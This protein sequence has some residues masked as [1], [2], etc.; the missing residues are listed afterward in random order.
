MKA[1]TIEIFLPGGNPLELE[2]ATLTTSVIKVV[3]INQSELENSKERINQNGCYVLYGRDE[4]EESIIY[5]GEADNIF[6]RLKQH[7]KSKNFWNQ[8]YAIQHIGNRF[9]KANLHFLE[10][11]MIKEALTANRYR[12]ANGNK[13]QKNNITESKEAESINFFEDIKLILHTLGLDLFKPKNSK[14]NLNVTNIFYFKSHSVGYNASAIYE[15]DELT[16]L[17]GSIAAFKIR[18]SNNKSNGGLQ[19]KLIS[20]DVLKENDGMYVFVK[21]YTFTSPSAAGGI[22]SGSS[23]NGWT[24]WKNANNKTL[25]EMFRNK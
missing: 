7:K 25:D 17:E 18:K 16:V 3:H 1:K 11:L 8:A 9:D 23:T 20:E 15:N 10:N 14:V 12:V 2:E 19:A 24:A 21:D 6:N 13:G 5:I 22:V 4:N